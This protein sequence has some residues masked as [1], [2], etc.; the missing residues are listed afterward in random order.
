[1]PEHLD[2]RLYLEEKFNSLHAKL[3]FIKDQTT[4]TNNRVTHLEEQRDQYLETRVDVE[5]LEKL[6]NK[7]DCFEK[8]FE[9]VSFFIR[10]P[11]ILIT[12]LVTLVL[13]SLATAIEG[14]IHIDPKPTIEVLK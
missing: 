7:L 2:Y 6:E 14:G 8:K 1:M 13:I 10:H 12:L 5:T 4:K 9:D 11:K 3:D